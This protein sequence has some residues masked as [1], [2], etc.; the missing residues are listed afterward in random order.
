MNEPENTEYV[1]DTELQKLKRERIILDAVM[2]GEV[3]SRTLSPKSPSSKL[4]ELNR[5]R[6]AELN[7]KIGEI[8]VMRKKTATAV[9]V[10]TLRDAL[11]VS[12]VEMRD[13]DKDAE[14][15]VAEPG[16]DVRV[17]LHLEQ[18]YHAL[19]DKSYRGAGLKRDKLDEAIDKMV[20]HGRDTP[21]QTIKWA[22]AEQVMKNISGSRKFWKGWVRAREIQRWIK[23]G[24]AAKVHLPICKADLATVKTWELWCHAYL[25]RLKVFICMG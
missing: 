15:A 1:T 9:R 22:D 12:R 20:E 14:T 11:R 21:L 8:E 6:L 4:A 3:T 2:K 23:A 24:E 19:L 16:D 25:D 10:R 18:I 17:L 7:V 5:E 13:A